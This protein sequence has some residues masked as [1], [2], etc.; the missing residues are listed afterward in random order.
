[1]I[2]ESHSIKGHI[3]MP[4]QCHCT[5]MHPEDLPCASVPAGENLFVDD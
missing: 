5:E 2:D 3:S 1:M 4:N